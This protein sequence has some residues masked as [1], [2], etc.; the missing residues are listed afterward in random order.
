MTLEDWE[1]RFQEYLEQHFPQ[2]DKAHDIAHFS[3]VWK[4]AR[5]IMQFTDAD[6]RI[7]AISTMWSISPKITP[8][9]IWHH[10]RL[11]CAHE[12]SSLT[13]FP[14]SRRRCMAV[15]RMR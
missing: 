10:D 15:W 7:A 4:T 5:K 9:V 2:D 11:R 14:I 6:E 1:R 3:R 13:I 12:K 8:N